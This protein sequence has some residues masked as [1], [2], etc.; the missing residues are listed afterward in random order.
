[1]EEMKFQIRSVYNYGK[2]NKFI[3]FKLHWDLNFIGIVIF[4]YSILTSDKTNKKYLGKILG[5]LI[6]IIG[7]ICLYI[8]N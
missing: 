7:C 3:E 4:A 6:I 5:C 2:Y 1:M 8:N